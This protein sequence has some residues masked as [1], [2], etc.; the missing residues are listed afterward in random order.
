[1]DPGRL[2]SSWRLP[3]WTENL[4]SAPSEGRVLWVP[5]WT[6]V[7]RRHTIRVGPLGACSCYLFSR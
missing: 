7:R 4:R 3:R 1:M 6:I 2:A 5:F